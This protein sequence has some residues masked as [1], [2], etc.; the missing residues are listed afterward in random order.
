MTFTATFAVAGSPATPGTVDF[1]DGA[2]VLCA[3]EPVDTNGVAACSTTF[4]AADSHPIVATFAQTAIYAAATASL[5][6]RRRPDP[7]RDRSG[8]QQYALRGR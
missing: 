4:V 1:T 5:Q 8:R 6:L 2:T 7:H 3:A